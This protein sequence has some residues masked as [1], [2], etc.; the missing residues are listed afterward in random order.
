MLLKAPGIQ[1]FREA[2]KNTSKSRSRFAAAQGGGGAGA[3]SM[4]REDSSSG[5]ATHGGEKPLMYD[6]IT[7]TD[8]GEIVF[9]VDAFE[10]E[11]ETGVKE[12]DDTES[13]P[14][15]DASS[16]ASTTNDAATSSVDDTD[17]TADID[18]HFA[19]GDDLSDVSK[20]KDHSHSNSSHGSHKGKHR[21][22]KKMMG[23]GGALKLGNKKD[24]CLVDDES[25][26]EYEEMYSEEGMKRRAEADREAS[27]AGSQPYLRSLHPQGPPPKQWAFDDVVRGAM[28][29]TQ[30]SWGKVKSM[31]RK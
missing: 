14:S 21:L 23:M 24:A 30:T 25:E 8:N 9:D 4:N 19:E 20:K 12:D 18:N 31:V 11:Q 13:S 1:H 28:H 3:G 2:A 26:D 15:R 17:T 6:A 10:K 7:Q 27:A 22:K 5:D 16:S 29:S